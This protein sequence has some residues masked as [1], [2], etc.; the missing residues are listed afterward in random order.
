MSETQILI[1]LLNAEIFGSTEIPP[2]DFDEETLARLFNLSKKHDVLQIIANALLKD[3][4][5]Q[6]VDIA[7][8]F[9]NKKM[10]SVFRREQ[11][12]F[13][14]ERVC[15]LFDENNIDYIPLK[16]AVLKNLYPEKWM[17]TSCDVD[18]LI[19]ES[20]L[21]RA[22]WLLVNTLGMTDEGKHFHDVSFITKNNINIELHFSLKEPYEKANGVLERVWDHAKKQ[23]GSRFGLDNEFLIFYTVAHMQAHFA[24]GGCGVR[25]FV[26]L[27]L[28]LEKI[29]FS[30]EKLLSMFEESGG[31]KFFES[32][33]M[34]LEVWFGGKEHSALTEAMESY[35]LSGGAF[36]TRATYSAAVQHREGGKL[37][38]F[39]SR[40]FPS[41]ERMKSMFPKLNERPWLLP[42]YYVKR[43]FGLLDKNRVKSISRE[44]NSKEKA[45]NISEMMKELGV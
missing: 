1:D 26:D 2:C 37:G 24:D 36:G 11:T 33:L 32:V 35:I 9:Y 10:F 45:F 15:K 41:R 27:K 16:G 22:S 21:E 38:Y 23:D 18:I 31:V 7:K 3:N 40:I 19:R 42:F 34:L 25:P 6:N 20:D 13:E 30:K 29:D 17:R 5:I 12:D 8:A 14:E 44:F 4:L 39:V 28:L 43:W